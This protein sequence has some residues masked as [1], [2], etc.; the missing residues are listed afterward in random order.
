VPIR[1]FPPLSGF[2][3]QHEGVV[4]EPPI[5]K[6]CYDQKIVDTMMYRR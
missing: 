2:W 4:Q 1:V 5:I 3:R 6:P